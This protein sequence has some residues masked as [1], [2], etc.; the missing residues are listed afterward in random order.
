MT[1]AST[2]G[3]AA[4]STCQYCG[5]IHGAKCPL[6]K[7]IEYEHGMVKRVEFFAPNDYAQ[8]L[9]AAVPLNPGGWPPNW[10][11][12]AIMRGHA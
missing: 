6:V 2:T 1:G 5:M 7:A 8:P 3:M 10:S 4:P 12:A 9:A 11:T